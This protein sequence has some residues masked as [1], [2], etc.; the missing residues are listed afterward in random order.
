[1]N[2]RN[3]ETF[4]IIGKAAQVKAKYCCDVMIDDSQ[5]LVILS[6]IA[7]SKKITHVKISNLGNG[8]F[9]VS[10]FKIKSR[11]INKLGMLEAIPDNLVQA[12]DGM[13]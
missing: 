12:I 3:K 13:L 5:D 11:S 4:S 8:N 9:I 2:D 1:M 7:V 6:D 10:F